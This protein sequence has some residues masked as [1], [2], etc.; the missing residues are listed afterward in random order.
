MTHAVKRP[1][2]QA[3]PELGRFLFF[4]TGPTTSSLTESAKEVPSVSVIQ[5][6]RMEAASGKADELL[7]LLQQGRDFTLT[8]D[9][10]EAFDLYQGKDDPHQLLMIERWVSI[11]AHQVHFEKNVMATGLL[12]RC[13]ALMTGPPQFTYYLPR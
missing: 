12:D 13:T 11:D 3:L 6:V 7:R 5:L 1:Y 2:A 8:V 10:C 4:T 9:G